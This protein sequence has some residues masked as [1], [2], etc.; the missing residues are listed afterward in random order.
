MKNAL[1]ITLETAAWNC[2]E[3]NPSVSMPAELEERVR[4]R[5]PSCSAV[6]AGHWVGEKGYQPKKVSYKTCPERIQGPTILS[7]LLLWCCLCWYLSLAGP[8][9]SLF[10]LENIRWLRTYS[11]LPF[12]FV[13]LS[14]PFFD[15]IWSWILKFWL[16]LAVKKWVAWATKNDQIPQ[17]GKWKVNQKCQKSPHPRGKI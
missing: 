2:L 16:N 12:C 7:G 10:F 4:W 11:P 1:I 6:L 9:P 17:G 3:L 15:L 5:R 14:F 8:E 13:F